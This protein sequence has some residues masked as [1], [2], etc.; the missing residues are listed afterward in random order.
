MVLALCIVHAADEKRLAYQE[1]SGGN[2]FREHQEISGGN[3][4]REHQEISGGNKVR[5]HQEISGG[6]KVGEHQEISGG[7]E[8]REHKK[9]SGGNKFR[10]HISNIRRSRSVPGIA[11]PAI[12]AL[13]K[14]AVEVPTTS[15][16]Y[17]KFIKEGNTQDA[18]AD[19][20]KLNP[21]NVV[22]RRFTTA[23]F[24]SDAELLLKLNM[25][26][27]PNILIFDPKSA[28]PVK[29]VYFKDIPWYLCRHLKTQ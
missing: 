23:G 5:E 11:N 8:V 17:R 13:I 20:N 7:N 25:G 22:Q 14:S 9:I 3:E 24:V 12:K 10:E 18:I 21:T 29:I 19:F 27:R 6:N 26:R 15:Q 4:V 16:K 2:K 1:I 28:S